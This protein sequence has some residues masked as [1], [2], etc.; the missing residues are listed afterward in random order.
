MQNYKIKKELN[1]YIKNCLNTGYSL[2]STHK[3]LIKI[4]YGDYADELIRNYKIKKGISVAIPIVLIALI[5]G[6]FFF[7]PAITGFFAVEKQFSYSDN[8]NVKFNESS[9]Y[10]WI[11]E[12]TGLLTSLKLSGSYKTEGI[13]KVYLED[14]DVRYLIF[15]STSS[16]SGL[17][18]ITGLVVSNETGKEKEIQCGY[19]QKKGKEIWSRRI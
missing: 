16:E 19:L 7:K 10:I 2:R 15:D 9:E 1:R 14:G 17:V 18:G 13:V 11:P 4:G 5:F 8:I 12:H 3:A 6:L